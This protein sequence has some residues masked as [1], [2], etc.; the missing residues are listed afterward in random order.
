MSFVSADTKYLHNILVAVPMI[1]HTYN[2]VKHRA[3]ANTYNASH[4]DTCRAKYSLLFLQVSAI[5]RFGGRSR[6]SL[7]IFRV[8]AILRA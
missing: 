5:L 7:L 8:N 2:T 1:V 4:C 6:G 3:C